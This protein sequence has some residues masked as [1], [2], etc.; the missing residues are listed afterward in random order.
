MLI[1]NRDVASVIMR[2]A[3][4]TYPLLFLA[5]HCQVSG[6][7]LA[8]ALLA[9]ASIA[10]FSANTFSSVIHCAMPESASRCVA[11]NS[12]HFLVNASVDL[13]RA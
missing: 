10:V 6:Y 11:T 9:V 8:R 1:C 3:L 13:V 4:G 5:G 7:A 12:D 2:A